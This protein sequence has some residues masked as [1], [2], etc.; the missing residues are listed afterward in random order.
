MLIQDTSVQ[1]AETRSMDGDE[2]NEL[3][4]GPSRRIGC[5]VVTRI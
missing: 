5:S 3:I 4:A 1:R 2:A